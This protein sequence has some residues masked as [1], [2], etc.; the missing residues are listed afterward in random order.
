MKTLYLFIDESGNFD[1]SPG[2]TKYFVLTVLSTTYPYS[3]GSKLLELRYDLLP[4]Y[5]CGP[6]ME[7][8]GYFHASED[9]NAVRNRVYSAFTNVEQAFRVD[10]V[11]AQKNKT[12]PSLRI[13]TEFYK[14]L[15]V[16]VLKFAFNRAAW[17]GYEQIVAVFSNLFNRK[18]RG[19]LK[20]AFKSVIKEYAQV[21]YALYFHDTKF[22]LC[23]Q[24]GD[25]FCWAIYGKWESA[26]TWPYEKARSFI[27]SEYPIFERG[28]EEYY[29]YKK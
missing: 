21:P 29:A 5:A 22:D 10:A 24:A 20:Q 25:Y 15:G 28:A 6:S 11:I 17:S 4:S 8:R 2:G 26:R 12:C 19:A 23:N 13:P 27:K 18:E 3:I 9:T 14:L 16:T 1:F 7:D